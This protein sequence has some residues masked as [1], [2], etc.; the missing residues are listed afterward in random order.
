MLRRWFALLLPLVLVAAACSS[1]T[2]ASPTV[3]AAPSHET[4]NSDAGR[5]DGGAGGG[6]EEDAT[7]ATRLDA[8]AQARAAGTFGNN[9]QAT[10]NGAATGWAGEQVV[11]PN[12]DDWEPAV[13]TDPHA[14]YI[15][16]LTTRYG[17][18]AP[19]QSHCPS[20]YITLTVSSDNGATWGDQLPIW[21]G[22]G[23]KAQYDPTITVVPNNGIVYAFF[24]NAD[25][26][27]GFSTL[28]IK[29]IDHGKT[30]TNPV[31][32]NG[33]VSWTDKPELT[34]SPTGQDVYVSWNGPTGG[35]LWV[36]LSH[37]YGATW[38][39]IRVVTSKRYFYAYDGV[40]LPD[41]TVIFSESSFRYTCAG[42]GSFNCVSSG[43]VWHHAVISRDNGATWENVIVA[44]VPIGEACFSFGCGEFYTGQTSVA[45]D[46]H[47]RLVFAYE[48]PVI[49]GGPQTSYVTIS[50][51]EGRSWGNATA[52]SVNGEDS[53]QPRVVG[54][55]NGNYRLWYMQTSD[56]DL[57]KSDGTHYWNVWHRS[58][59]NGGL[60]WSAPL[61]ISDAPVG[62]APYVHTD[63]SGNTGF[64][65]I[66]GDYGEIDITSTGKTIAVWGEGISY[67]GPG[68]CWF[69][70]Q[71]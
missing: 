39:Q 3:N 17:Q 37:D 61:K 60:T 5:G 68:G 69:N 6:S 27:G 29:S 71:T 23:S 63:P 24:L 28:F 34:T 30:W 19:C 26:H 40:V 36:A 14:P 15:Y 35:D 52:V 47:G 7:T 44:K 41:G 45:T 65:E 4:G 53:T 32:P 48:G 58:S 18:P 21:G 12:V 57:Q 43:E 11:N 38:K 10:T 8:L 31:R 22:K 1:R 9:R 59:T 13:A 64:D 42:S 62:A 25:R 50:T 2:S 70:I 67:F 66:Y 55:G 51:N 46:A 20:P 56:G 33:Q 54:T 49:D 16:I